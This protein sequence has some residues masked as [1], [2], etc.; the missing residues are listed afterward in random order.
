MELQTFPN[1]KLPV[2]QYKMK[3]H[4]KQTIANERIQQGFDLISQSSVILCGIARDCAP[5]L[6]RLIPKLENLAEKFK[7][8]KIIVVENDSVDHTAKI[9]T[10]WAA[11]NHNVIPIIFTRPA[12][13]HQYV[14]DDFP[15]NF[16]HSRIS[17]IAFARNMYLNE[18][19]QH[20]PAD[21]VII[22]DLDIMNF[23]IPGIANSIGW[24]NKWECATSSGLR[25]TLRAPFSP[26]V[27]W[28]AF[29]YEP[30]EGF[31]GGIQSLVDMRSNQKK[32][33]KQIREKELIPASSAFGGLAIYKYQLLINQQYEVL[34]NSNPEVPVLC[35]HVALHRSM[36]G[37]NAKFRLVINPV[38]ELRYESP[39]TTIRR[40]IQT[41]LKG[42][43]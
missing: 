40:N 37:S 10:S 33:R 3:M 27:Y 1:Q 32:L 30:E 15:G 43:S 41:L 7:N 11:S 17:R 9:I 13:E 4:M 12:I 5:Q 16:D 24:C 39:L 26:T 21:F 38:Q 31:P 28:D 6:S 8:Y 18:L 29:A 23:S 36:A 25:Y 2:F 35:E 22:V 20:Q 34:A 19:Q 42:S 14:D